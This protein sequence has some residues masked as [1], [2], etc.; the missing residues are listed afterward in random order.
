VGG[1]VWVAAAAENAAIQRRVNGIAIE[2]DGGGG[3]SCVVYGHSVGSQSTQDV[4]YAQQTDIQRVERGM[5][6]WRFY[7]SCDGMGP[8]I[9]SVLQSWR[10]N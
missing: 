10:R 3:G 9:K 8:A 7:M 5:L 1:P 6:L 2:S 4:L